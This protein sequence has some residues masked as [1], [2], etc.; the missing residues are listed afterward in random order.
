MALRPRNLFSLRQPNLRW[1]PTN[2]V[3]A[4]KVQPAASES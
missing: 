2:L 4:P 3:A 1:E